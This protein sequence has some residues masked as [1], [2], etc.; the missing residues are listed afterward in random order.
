MND[1]PLIVH[2]LY[3]LDTGGMERMLVTLINQTCQRYRHAVIC[4]EG[5]GALRDQI[6][7][8]DVKC[9]ALDKAPGKDWRCYFKLWR[10]LRNLKPD[11]VH[12]YNIG[13]VDVAPVARLAG[14]RRVVHAER[15]RDAADPR[16]E[17]RKYR[18][19]R[20]W[21]LPFIDRYLAV[22]TDLQNWL[23]EKVGIPSSRVVCIPNG[24]DV[25]A[26]A[27][28]AAEGSARTLLG[29]FA[30]P[31]TVLIGTVGRLDAVKDQAGLIAAFRILCEA[32]PHERERLR[33]VLLGEGSQRAA[34]ESRIA[35]DGLLT[36]VRLLGNR[37]DV[38]ALFAEFDVFALSSIAEGMPGVLLEAMAS[39]LPVVA[40]DVGGVGEV[41][42]SGVTGTLVSASDPKAL[43]VALRDYVLDEGLRTKHGAAGRERAVT[44][45]SLQTMLSAYTEL[46]DGLLDGTHHQH[47]QI[48]AAT[49]A[50]E[51]KES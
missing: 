50:T 16:G 23:I 34:L 19:L 33:L 26:F 35:R 45:F 31:G 17:S 36:Q 3:R 22:S 4:L 48:V 12:T 21:L 6:E 2:V 30:P 38:A 29:P 11:L 20:R 15:G 49:R 41:V 7:P 1:K 24:I 10:V 37:S 44:R 18:L 47:Q 27:A 25:T 42:V 43:A 5:Y 40:T 8:D 46:Y 28:A 14:V 13:A 51:H 39:G 9:V 32:L